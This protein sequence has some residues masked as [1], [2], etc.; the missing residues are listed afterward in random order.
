M[1]HVVEI[2]DRAWGLNE[3]EVRQLVVKLQP[4]PTVP[5]LLRKLQ[6]RKILR[7]VPRRK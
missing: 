4:R 3:D 1:K 6:L 2:L 7:V 5:D